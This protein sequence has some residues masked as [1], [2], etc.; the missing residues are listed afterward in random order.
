MN[1]LNN[2]KT[3]SDIEQEYLRMLDEEVPDLWNR[4]EAGIDQNDG[5]TLNEFEPAQI[6][7]WQQENAYFRE[8]GTFDQT[9]YG[10]N[11]V[12]KKKGRRRIVILAGT[13]AAAAAL[14]LAIFAMNGGF[15]RKNESTKSDMTQNEAANRGAEESMKDAEDESTVKKPD[16][17]SQ[18][19]EL[20]HDKFSGKE[21][22]NINNGVKASEAQSFEPAEQPAYE[23]EGAQ[24][25][26]D[27]VSDRYDKKKGLLPVFEETDTRVYQG[28]IPGLGLSLS[29]E[30][31]TADGGNL[32]FSYV[33]NEQVGAGECISG[34]YY[35]LERKNGN[36]WE[37]VPLIVDR[38]EV[39]W[40]DIGW[41]VSTKRSEWRTVW[42]RLYGS[43]PSGTYRIIKP[44]NCSHYVGAYKSFL[45]SAEFRIP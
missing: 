30:D 31:A 11:T 5:R 3:E 20:D 35:E 1:D 10:Q 9:G 26:D 36:S 8:I 18:Y 25:N 28:T 17:N 23:A 33:E 7:G 19:S 44:V 27:A 22:I 14:F 16:K 32:V 6:Y 34:T 2:K 39:F 12:K 21:S 29:V 38:S 45:I 42:S 15:S 41:I 24:E 37:K 13:L 4:I 43:L 40:E